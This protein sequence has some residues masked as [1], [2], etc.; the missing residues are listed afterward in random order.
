MST[1]NFEFMFGRRLDGFLGQPP[2]RYFSNLIP[3]V[4]ARVLPCSPDVLLIH[5]LEDL[6]LDA[7]AFLGPK[8]IVTVAHE[9]LAQKSVLL[10]RAERRDTDGHLED[11]VEK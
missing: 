6:R 2:N 8:L 5:T 1:A 10:R 7:L 9:Q 4:G 11:L 3:N